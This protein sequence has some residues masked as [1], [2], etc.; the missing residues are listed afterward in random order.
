MALPSRRGV[1]Y[2]VTLCHCC[3]VVRTEDDVDRELELEESIVDMDSSSGAKV[4]P[5]AV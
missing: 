3:H 1:L 5:L 4:Q 2:I